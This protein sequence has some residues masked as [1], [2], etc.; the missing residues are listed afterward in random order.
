MGD[1][2]LSIKGGLQVVL[3]ATKFRNLT[4]EL[5]NLPTQWQSY[6]QP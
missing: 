3:I 1:L 4:E 6:V 2:S 5:S